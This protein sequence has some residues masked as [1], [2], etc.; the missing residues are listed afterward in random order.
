MFFTI[1]I[2][3]LNAVKFCKFIKGKL[4]NYFIQ[5]FIIKYNQT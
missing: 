4:A 3:G 2:S 1:T 5:G